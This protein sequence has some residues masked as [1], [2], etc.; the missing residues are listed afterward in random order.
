MN[1]LTKEECLRSLDNLSNYIRELANLKDADV[2][3]FAQCEK[4]FYIN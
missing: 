1:K 4:M 2:N 3:N